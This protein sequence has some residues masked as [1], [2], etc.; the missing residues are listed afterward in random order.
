[1][2]ASIDKFGWSRI[3]VVTV[4][5]VLGF[6]GSVLFTTG[7]GLHWLDIVDHFL[8]AYGLITVGLLECLLIIWYYRIDHLHFHLSDSSEGGYPKAWDIW[9]EFSVKYVAPLALLLILFWSAAEDFAKPYEGYPPQ[10]LVL[11]GG[12]WLAGTFLLAGLFST[13]TKH[14]N[15][16]ER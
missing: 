11:I 14:Q 7:A 15:P 8:N 6:L 2:S 5:C 3:P 16:L 10:A 4:S 9:W 1:V 12:G 13:Y